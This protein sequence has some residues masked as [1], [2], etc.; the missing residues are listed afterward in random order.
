VELELEQCL[1]DTP[2][3]SVAAD[4]KLNPPVSQ[5]VVVPGTVDE[6]AGQKKTKGGK[7]K[8]NPVPE[9]GPETNANPKGK[10]KGKGKEK[11]VVPQEKPKPKP[12]PT[13]PP[14]ERLKISMVHGDVLILSGGNYIVRRVLCSPGLDSGAD[15]FNSAVHANANR[16]VYL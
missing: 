12:K 8:K 15:L 4:T 3:P 6:G 1:P 13:A 10:R 14:H 16:D 2:E 11:A 5:D 7:Q 9:P